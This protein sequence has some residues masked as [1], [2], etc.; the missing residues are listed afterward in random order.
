MSLSIWTRSNLISSVFDVE[1]LKV[2]ERFGVRVIIFWN[3][4]SRKQPMSQTDN[5]WISG[6]NVFFSHGWV[7]HETFLS[8]L[9]HMRHFQGTVCGALSLLST[10]WLHRRVGGSKHVRILPQFSFSISGV[11]LSSVPR[12]CTTIHPTSDHDGFHEDCLYS[13][14]YH[15]CCVSFYGYPC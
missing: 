4:G 8:T 3:G 11:V 1:T 9:I 12:H 7:K 2:V 14:C 6:I 10:C 13:L 15:Q 5:M